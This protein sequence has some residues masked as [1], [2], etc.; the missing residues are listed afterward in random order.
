MLPIAADPTFRDAGHAHQSQPKRS[1]DASY[2]AVIKLNTVK[3][4]RLARRAKAKKYALIATA[5]D[6]DAVDR[7]AFFVEQGDAGAR[8]GLVDLC[9]NFIH[10]GP[11]NGNGRL[12]DGGRLLVALCVKL[13]G[14]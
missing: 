12:S 13:F 5:T 3:V 6:F 4:R 7:F 11:A 2:W 10:A 9:H 1:V 8:C 14:R